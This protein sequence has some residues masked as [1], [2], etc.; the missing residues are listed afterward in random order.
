MN[1]TGLVLDYLKDNPQD[2]P[3]VVVENRNKRNRQWSKWALALINIIQNP[4][5]PEHSKAILYRDEDVIIISDKFPKAKY[6]FLVL[7]AGVW[8]DTAADVTK[9]DIPI[10]EKLLER[11]TAFLDELKHKSKKAAMANFKM[12]FHGK[13]SMKQLHLHVISD[14]FNSPAMK[15]SKHYNTFTTPYF[16]DVHDFIDTVRRVGYYPVDFRELTKLAEGP[17]TCHK[18]GIDMGTNWY[19]AKQH[20]TSCDGT[21]PSDEKSDQS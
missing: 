9:N 3:E 19:D 12:G 17:M 11:A 14:D 2:E 15:H 10:L 7:P 5:I 21:I 8:I 18:C 4:E 1:S 20:Y 16:L 13:P 6:H